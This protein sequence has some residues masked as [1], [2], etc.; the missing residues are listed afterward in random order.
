VMQ[1]ADQRHVANQRRIVHY[2]GHKSD[3]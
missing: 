2:V 1:L 3:F